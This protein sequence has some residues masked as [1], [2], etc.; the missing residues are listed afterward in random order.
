MTMFFAKTNFGF[1]KQIVS[2]P[3]PE[4]PLTKKSL[5]TKELSN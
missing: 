1:K 4:S 5:I 2:L 3:L